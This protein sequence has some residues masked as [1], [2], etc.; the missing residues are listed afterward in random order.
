MS[1]LNSFLKKTNKKTR[2]RFAPSPTGYLHIGSARTAFFNWLYA[3]S[4]SGSLIL[5]IEDTD[6]KRH[7]EE[8]IRP[9]L[10]SLKW[11]G[12]TWDE[13]PDI[14]GDY[15]PYRQSERLE[16]YH[17]YANR[18]L[19]E[20]KAYYCFCSPA[21]LNQKRDTAAQ[22]GQFFTYDRSCLSL[23]DDEIE[24]RLQNNQAHCLR[25]YN[26]LA[27]DIKFADTVYKDISCSFSEIDDFIIIRS[28]GTPTYNF[29]AA[30]DDALMEIT[31]I[32]RG[33]DH[34]SNTPKQ[35]LL[36]DLLSF[37]R[38]EFCH[39]PMILGPDGKKLS[40]RT[41]SVSVTDYI[42]QGFLPEAVLNFLVLLGW[43]LDDKTTLMDIDQILSVF[44]LADINKKAAMFDYDRLLF[45]NSHYIRKMSGTNFAS[46]LKDHIE[47]KN[48]EI[49][50]NTFDEKILLI[51]PII[52]E[53][54]R[55]FDECLD[56]LL[57]F[58]NEITYS[59]N[60]VGYFKNKAIDAQAI[61]Q[62]IEELM[63]KTDD[64]DFNRASIEAAIRQFA[65]HSGISLRKVAEV[66]RIAIW[67]EPV[68]PPLF[69]TIEILGK[70]NSL[71]RIRVY[72]KLISKV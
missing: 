29:S 62:A 50:R 2:V 59:E 64:L 47:S 67:G 42:G 19:L 37:D 13:G 51:F 63:S 3:Q 7:K 15:G 27:H 17:K 40:K 6:L 54:I 10:S 70:S 16:I 18:L 72:L 49:N 71:K 4:A 21:E 12:I 28:D 39:L 55:T 56:F 46:R 31:H 35:L 44:K 53:R 48:I 52:K 36:Y 68:S 8:T 60:T 41:S 14:G 26:N 38:P 30:I 5:R 61:L 69:E 34:L 45:I 58:F 1:T 23:R 66:I 65:E 32:I 33:E 11:L 43:S 57:K 9:I 22:N 24:H 25:V 20:K